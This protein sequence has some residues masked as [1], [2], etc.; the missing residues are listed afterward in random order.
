MRTI[1]RVH[2]TESTFVEPERARRW[3][4]GLHRRFGSV[5]NSPTTCYATDALLWR[6]VDLELISRVGDED[7]QQRRWFRPA[8]GEHVVGRSWRLAGRALCCGA[9]AAAA[10]GHH[11]G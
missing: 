10:V 3:Q 2:T 7:D 5:E 8:G 4:R 6:I 9:H 1:L 11:A